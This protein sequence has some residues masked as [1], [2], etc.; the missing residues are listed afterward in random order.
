VG[1]AT[2]ERIYHTM[3]GITGVPFTN[4]AVTT[5]YQAVQQSMPSAPQIAAFLPSHQTAISQM[6][7]VYCTQLVGTPAAFSK[8]FAGTGF[9]SLNANL[10]ATAAAYFGT[11][12]AGNA[13][14]INA[15]VQPLVNAI[16]GPTAYPQAAA[17][18]TTELNLLLPRIGSLSASE[19]VS[20][21]T[22]AACTAALGSAAATVQ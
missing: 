21:A 16:V 6:A 11:T 1:I 19:K 15:V 7:G 14:N 8:L 12:G 17:G 9:G 20:D 10:N 22:I 5:V 13:T 3:S 4:P 18:M 2:F